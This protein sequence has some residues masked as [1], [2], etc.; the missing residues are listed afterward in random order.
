M[1]KRNG[2]AARAAESARW[3]GG[4][5]V[6]VMLA[7]TAPAAAYV[8]E[9]TTSTAVPTADEDGALLTQAVT[10]ALEQVIHEAIA[11]TPTLIVLTD[12]VVVGGRL[13]LRVLIADQEGEQA[14]RDLATPPEDEGRPPEARS[15]LRL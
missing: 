11:F 4:L 14:F 1:R 5:L 6:L 3:L 13:Y 10:S 7:L 9:V 8:V 2:A 15:E 12:A